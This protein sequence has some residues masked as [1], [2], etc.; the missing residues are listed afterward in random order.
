[1]AWPERPGHIDN[2]RKAHVCGLPSDFDAEWLAE[3]LG[4]FGFRPERVLWTRTTAPSDEARGEIGE[5]Q[6][7]M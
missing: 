2:R 3:F 6:R 5:Q 4:A 7:P 1:M